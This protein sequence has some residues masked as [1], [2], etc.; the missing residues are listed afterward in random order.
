MSGLRRFDLR[1][2]QFHFTFQ[3]IGRIFISL[4]FILSVFFMLLPADSFAAETEKNVKTI[5]GNYLR[6][7]FNA[8]EGN[9]RLALGELEKARGLDPRSTYLR[10][11][12]AS[13]LIRLGEF[14]R[15]ETELKE[16]KAI[17]PEG[18]DVSLALIFLYSYS[19]KDKE[20]ED[21]YG[22]FLRKAH[23]AKPDDIRISEYLAQFYFYKKQPEEAIKLYEAIL[24]IKPE[25]VESM[26]WLGFIYEEIGKRQQAIV[27]WK[28]GL[29]IN[30]Q[31]DAILNSLGYVYAEE[32]I[33]LD[34]AERM[35]KKALEKQPDSGA[36]MDSLGWVYFKK[37]DYKKA[38]ESLRKAIVLQEDPVIYEHLGD[39]YAALKNTKEAA[40]CYKD[41]L[42]HFPDSKVLKEKLGKHGKENPTPKK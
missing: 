39:L 17:D 38:E 13:I 25:D 32:G 14:D 24:K 36:Y 18:L 10:L 41:G 5:Y 20:L 30:P 9:Y 19:Q 23:K 26:F 2:I 21:E 33:K 6:G 7:L 31:H 15:A 1:K 16:A 37:K 34:E 42:D 35:I 40:R 4:I 29:L 11:K 28:K 8:Q 12:I 27:I 22:E 3:P